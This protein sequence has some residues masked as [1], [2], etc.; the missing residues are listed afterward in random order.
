MPR[1]TPLRQTPPRP[2]AAIAAAPKKVRLRKN[3]SARS[4]LDLPADI[5]DRLKADDI[6]VQWVTD[7]VLGKEE[8]GIRQ[9]FEINAWEPVT[10]DMWGGLFD[11]MYTKKGHTG[12]IN[13]QGLVLMWRPMELTEEAKQEERAAQMGQL[14]AQA[15]MIKGG[16]LPGFKPGFEPDHPTAVRGNKLTRTVHAPMEIPTD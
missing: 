11:G 5:M 6:D 13:Y 12:E 10:P 9:S 15:N 3:A 7:S 4:M 2:A 14:Q 8:P 16:Q 1:A